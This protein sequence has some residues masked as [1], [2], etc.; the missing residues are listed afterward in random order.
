MAIIVSAGMPRSRHCDIT[1]T[2]KLYQHMGQIKELQ[3]KVLIFSKLHT[4]GPLFKI[5]D[6]VV[7]ELEH[8]TYEERLRELALLSLRNGRLGGNLT[9][10]V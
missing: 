7:L 9:M 5:L 4:P 10:L 2:E 1:D 6:H 3:P 8:L